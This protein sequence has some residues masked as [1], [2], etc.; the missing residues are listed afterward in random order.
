MR[1]QIT[2]LRSVN[3]VFFCFQYL[4]YCPV[5]VWL[6]ENELKLCKALLT[7]KMRILEKEHLFWIEF[8]VGC[9]AFKNI[10]GR[11]EGWGGVTLTRPNK[12]LTLQAKWIS[13]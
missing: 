9:F 1:D 4:Y 13:L 11:G 10:W 5:V 3:L 2:F 7:I 8:Q 12:T 6:M